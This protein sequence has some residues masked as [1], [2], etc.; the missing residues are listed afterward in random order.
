MAQFSKEFV[1]AVNHVWSQI[2]HDILQCL[3]EDPEG[4]D[5]EACVESCIDAGML[6]RY[7]NGHGAAAEAEFMAR[8]DVIGYDKAL[9]E[10]AN[11][12]PYRLV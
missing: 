12:L 6:T 11:S 7:D 9:T 8:A 1:S 10:A 4:A 3:A 5:N 2:G